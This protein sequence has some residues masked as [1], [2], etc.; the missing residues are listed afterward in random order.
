[1]KSFIALKKSTVV[2]SGEIILDQDEKD[3]I[4]DGS[5][6]AIVV[7]L[8]NAVPLAGW[9]RIDLLD[10][11]HTPL[12]TISENSNGTDTLFFEGANVDVNGEV[13][14][15]YINQPLTVELNSSQLEM[16]TR[17]KFVIYS[18]SLR[19]SDAFLNPPRVV[20][21]RPDAW[22]KVRSFGSVNYRINP[23]GN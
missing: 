18:V 11:N 4:L 23:E 8:E 10:E 13:R 1:M 16:L 22:I 15:S 12:F 6:A 9:L 2:D 3:A 20:A 21:L 17:T 14:S 5:A 7:E 19:T